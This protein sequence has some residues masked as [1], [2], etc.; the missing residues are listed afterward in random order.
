MVE[1]EPN[2]RRHFPDIEIL[3]EGR[4]GDRQGC[5]LPADKVGEGLILLYRAEA[6]VT[7]AIWSMSVPRGRPALVEDREKSRPFISPFLN[8]ASDLVEA[9]ENARG[10]VPAVVIIT[11]SG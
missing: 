4:R 5:S 2:R 8:S 11:T 3:A 7:F 9:I 10:R 1:R 6:R